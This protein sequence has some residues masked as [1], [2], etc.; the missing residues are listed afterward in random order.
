MN[1]IAIKIIREAEQPIAGMVKVQ[2]H[3]QFP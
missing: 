2:L 3:R 1:S